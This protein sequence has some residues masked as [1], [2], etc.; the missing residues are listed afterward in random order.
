MFLAGLSKLENI[1]TDC[2][3]SLLLS[4]EDKPCIEVD[5]WIVLVV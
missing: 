4:S 3:E 1:S 2:I 5:A